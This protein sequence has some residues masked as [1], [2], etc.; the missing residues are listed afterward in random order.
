MSFE[1]DWHAWRESREQRLRDPYGWLSITAIHW[2]TD[3]PQ[4]FDDVPGEWRQDDDGPVVDGQ[5]LG[6]LDEEGVTVTF[7]DVRAQVAD[8]DGRT[9]V[10]PRRPDSPALGRYGGTPCYPPDPAWVVHA[11]HDGDEVVFERDGAEHRLEAEVEEDGRL[12]ILF[13]DATS[14]VTTYAAMRQLLTEVPDADGNVEIDFN[15]AYNMPCAYTDFATCPV[16]PAQNTLPFPVEAGEQ[17]PRMD[18]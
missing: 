7:G 18:P 13:R 6:P 15:R 3:E 9:M 11:R 17:I 10:R 16:P 4:R 2:L 14:G 8:R 5:R 12:W 1:Q